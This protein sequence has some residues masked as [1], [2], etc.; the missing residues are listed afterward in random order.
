MHSAIEPVAYRTG[1]TLAAGHWK[2]VINLLAYLLRNCHSFLLLS[3]YLNINIV[4][5]SISGVV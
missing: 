5:M 2:S 1:Q 4:N 3:H